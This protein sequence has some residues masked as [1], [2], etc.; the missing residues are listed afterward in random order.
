MIRFK[1]ELKLHSAKIQIPAIM[2]VL[3]IGLVAIGFFIF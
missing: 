2:A 3:A 1:P